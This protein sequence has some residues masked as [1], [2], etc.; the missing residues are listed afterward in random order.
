M[1]F[2]TG[3]VFSSVSTLPLAGTRSGFA[4]IGTHGVQHHL[5]GCLL[6]IR[7]VSLAPVVADRVGEDVSIA[8]EGSTGDGSADGRVAL[9]TMLGILIPEV[10]CAVTSR[11]AE[12]AV[13]R[14]EL[15]RVDGVNVADVPVGGGVFT[16]TLEREVGG[17]VFLL[18]VLNGATTFDTAD[19]K[20]GGIGEAA[21]YPRLPLERG[22]HGLVEF[23]RLVKVDHVDVPIGG[24][25]H[26]QLVLHVHGVH[27]FLTL[28][29]RDGRLLSQIPV[30]DCLIP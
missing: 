26:E 6:G 18:D 9:Q 14:V 15:D 4:L 19:S 21:D 27:S 13:H 1:F 3:Y 10:E 7:R 11:G 5:V 28:H 24:S 16:M 20:P 30:L 12:C 25:D 23:G 17:G 2:P 29:R 8:V 22:L